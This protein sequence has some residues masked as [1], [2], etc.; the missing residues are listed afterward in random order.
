M[1]Y[2]HGKHS[3]KLDLNE[4]DRSC[5]V[6]KALSSPVRLQLLRLLVQQSMTMGELAQSLYVSLSSISMHTKVLQEAGLITIIPKPGMHGAQKICGI[7]SD[8]VEFDFFSSSNTTQNLQPVMINIPVG[9][10]CEANICPPCGIVSNKN[11]VDIED[12]PYCFFEPGHTDAQLIWFTSGYLKYRISNKELAAQNVKAISVSFEVCAEAPGYN[13][14]WPSDIYIKLND[15]FITQFRV[16]GDYGGM[17]GINNPSWWS[18][19]NTQ[20]GELKVLYIDDREILLNGQKVSPLSLSDLKLQEG[21][22]F[23]LELGVSS[24]AHYKGG[25]NL[26]GSNFGNYAQDIRIEVYYK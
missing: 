18:E 15:H 23:L 3:F 7:R 10:Y 6:A 16:K 8:K 24:E 4:I 20:Y 22:T 11:Y 17:R 9:C 5:L 12:T 14:D 21:Y 13:N 1:E 26:F 2:S 19:S 25:M